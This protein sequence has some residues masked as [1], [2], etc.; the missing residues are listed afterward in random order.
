MVPLRTRKINNN[1]K[2]NYALTSFEENASE[3][4][5]KQHPIWI[6]LG[7]YLVTGGNGKKTRFFIEIL[8]NPE[9]YYN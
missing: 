4:V 6:L 7:Y 1:D 5:F 9:L 8:D 3:V 2:T